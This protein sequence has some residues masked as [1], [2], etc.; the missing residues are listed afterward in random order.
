MEQLITD[1][2]HDNL[3][4]LKLTQ[5]AEV[6]DTILRPAADWELASLLADATA[7]E[8][9]VEIM[10]LP[11]WFPFHLSKI[12]YWSRTVVVPASSRPRIRSASM[13]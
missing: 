12:A 8:M 7:S 5:A 4:R 2:L 1:R 10:L 11:R 13:R 6:L 3:S 9:P